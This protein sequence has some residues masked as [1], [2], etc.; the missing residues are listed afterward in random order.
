MPDACAKLMYFNPSLTGTIRKQGTL[1][2][3]CYL[4]CLGPSEIEHIY[5][6]YDIQ[7]A[8][9]QSRSFPQ[10]SNNLELLF[11]GGVRAA[12]TFRGFVPLPS[13]QIPWGV[14][15]STPP[16]NY[17]WF[18]NVEVVCCSRL[19]SEHHQFIYAREKVHKNICLCGYDI[20]ICTRYI[21]DMY[22]YTYLYLFASYIH[23]S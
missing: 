17:S 9:K 4:Y 2:Q 14:E 8:H 18:M 6:I 3:R 20:G 11:V 21:Y 19:W 12:R 22:V 15:P 23:V 16:T 5:Y 13:G 10:T 1:L 7:G